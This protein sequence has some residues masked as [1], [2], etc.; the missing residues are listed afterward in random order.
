MKK[1]KGEEGILI[2][3][4]FFSVINIAAKSVSRN[5]H[6]FRLQNITIGLGE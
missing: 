5:V 1:K 6:D 2:Y 4:I 3:R